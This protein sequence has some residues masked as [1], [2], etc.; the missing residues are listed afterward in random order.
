MN[1]RDQIT[2]TREGVVH[3][4]GKVDQFK[5]ECCDIKKKV[6]SKMFLQTKMKDSDLKAREKFIIGQPATMN[7]AQNLEAFLT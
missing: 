2:T 6:A 4:L 5:Q 3:L 1:L 7:I